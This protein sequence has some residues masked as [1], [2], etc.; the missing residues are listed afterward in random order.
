MMIIRKKIKNKKI[1]LR[2]LRRAQSDSQN[3]IKLAQDS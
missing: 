2:A 3:L 1:P